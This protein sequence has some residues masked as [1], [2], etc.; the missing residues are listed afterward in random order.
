MN[1]NSSLSFASLYI[2]LADNPSSLVQ[3]RIARNLAHW[4]SELEFHF[5]KTKYRFDESE[6][7]FNETKFHLGGAKFCLPEQNVI[8][9]EFV[10]DYKIQL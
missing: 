7:R 10:A 9:Q 8:F 4:V 6:F 3:K 5:S 2:L 1:S